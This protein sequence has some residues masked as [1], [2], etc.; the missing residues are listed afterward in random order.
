MIKAVIFDCWGTIFTNSSIPHPFA[1]FAEKL[2][3]KISDRSFLKRFEQHM[4]TDDKPIPEHVASLL[5]ELEIN[6]TPDLISEL[7]NIILGS[8]STQISYGDTTEVLDR[9]KKDYCLILLSNTF[10]EGFMKLQTDYPINDWF[11]SVCLSYK[12]NMIKPNPALYEVVLR[13]ARLSKDE[14]LM[15]GDNYDDDVV[16]ANHAGIQ[17]ILLDRRG[18]YPEILD[19]KISSLHQLKA[20][21]KLK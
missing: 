4:M 7:T 18:R 17:A 15:I 21:L 1:V 13:Q 19:N 14:V 3:Y 10:R 9:L 2:G 16:A 11:E 5:T 8:L 12:E 6:P 20:L